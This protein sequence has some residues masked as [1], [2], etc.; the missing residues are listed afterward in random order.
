MS[1]GRNA[2]LRIVD[3]FVTLRL[4]LPGRLKQTI[5]SPPKLGRP[6]LHD[7]CKRPVSTFL[8]ITVD[9]ATPVLSFLLAIVP[10]ATLFFR[11]RL[12]STTNARTIEPSPPRK[13]VRPLFLLT[14]YLTR[15]GLLTS[16]GPLEINTR[17]IALFTFNPPSPRLPLPLP[18]G[19]EFPLLLRT[20]TRV[21]HLVVR[22]LTC[23]ILPVS[24]GVAK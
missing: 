1:A 17:K 23:N 7:P 15:D 2:N 20:Q 6:S 18:L 5:F 4:L 24:K 13:E 21:E 10:M 9:N 14:A 3:V 8:G 22:D 11:E 16:R 12:P 19:M